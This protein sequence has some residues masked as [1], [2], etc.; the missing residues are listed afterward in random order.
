M[1][2]PLTRVQEIVGDT[3]SSTA[4]GV[5]FIAMATAVSS[6]TATGSYRLA[7][8]LAIACFVVSAAAILAAAPRKV[9]VVSGRV[10]R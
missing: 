6:R 8:V 4:V 1:I 3:P 9:H 7:F 10:G 2:Y 5:A